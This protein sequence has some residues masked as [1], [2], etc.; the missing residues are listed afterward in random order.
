MKE[1]FDEQTL[2]RRMPD[3][4]AMCSRLF[5]SRY[6]T[7]RGSIYFQGSELV[8][9]LLHGTKLAICLLHGS[10]LVFFLLNGTEPGF[11][12]LYGAAYTH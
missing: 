6:S 9:L 1:L 12:S 10:E 3:A 5:R 2:L 8:F 11:C 7:P 4:H